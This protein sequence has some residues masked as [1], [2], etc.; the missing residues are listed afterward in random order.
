MAYTW[1]AIAAIAKATPQQPKQ[2]SYEALLDFQDRAETPAGVPNGLIFDIPLESSVVMIRQFTRGSG[3][4]HTFYDELV[5]WSWRQMLLSLGEDRGCKIVGSGV[6][7]I[8]LYER[9]GCYDRDRARAI[10]QQDDRI[11][12]MPPIWVWLVSNADGR[13]WMVHPHTGSKAKSA[14]ANKWAISELLDAAAN[15]G[16]VQV[17]GVDRSDRPD[18]AS[19]TEAVPDM[20][21]PAEA[22]DIPGQEL[23]DNYAWALV[24]GTGPLKNASDRDD[25]GGVAVYRGAGQPPSASVAA[26]STAKAWLDAGVEGC[27]AVGTPAVDSTRGCGG[28][29]CSGT[30]DGDA[31]SVAP[32]Q[33]V[34]E[35]VWYS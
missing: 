2:R 1:E 30:G 17:G 19:S 35:G 16:T 18:T 27:S 32:S 4:L 24:R 26:S 22:G 8:S 5:P 25:V 13:R 34:E 29:I 10:R 15:L 28:H 7:R 33:I 9:P 6:S 12:V 20:I 31:L 14:K 3:V 11:E 23:M 21:A